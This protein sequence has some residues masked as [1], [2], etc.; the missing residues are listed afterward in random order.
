MAFRCNKMATAGR[1]KHSP[2]SSKSLAPRGRGCN[3]DRGKREPGDGE[4]LFCSLG[5][6]TG[7]QGVGAALADSPGTG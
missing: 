1:G 7:V 2:D 3:R 5:G 4:G 6:Q